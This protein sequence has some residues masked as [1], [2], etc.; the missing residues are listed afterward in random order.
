MSA[1][2]E[3]EPRSAT[4]ASVTRRNSAGVPE[5]LQP[6]LGSKR[7]QIIGWQRRLT[8]LSLHQVREQFL[9][10]LGR[11]LAMEDRPLMENGP[12]RTGRQTLFSTLGPAAISRGGSRDFNQNFRIPKIPQILREWTPTAI[13]WDL[14][15]C[16]RSPRP[17]RQDEL[18]KR[19]RS[20]QAT[21][22]E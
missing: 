10:I 8:L 18:E 9:E 6:S 19:P 17:M 1:A 22:H 13:I 11:K 7:M 16:K 21:R 3:T 20:V 4:T 5:I 12:C 15:E 14:D 2:N